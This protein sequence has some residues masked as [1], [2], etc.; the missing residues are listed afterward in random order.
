MNNSK[1]QQLSKGDAIELATRM[2]NKAR[3][4]RLGAMETT[5]KVV[6]GAVSTVAAFAVGYWMGG[7][8]YEKSKLTEAEIEADGDPTK[9]AGMDK[10]LV[11]GV[12]VAGLGIANV[13]GRKVAPVLESAGFGTLAG[14]AYSRGDAQG[15]DAS[16]EAA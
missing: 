5:R 2:R 11:V 9:V 3:N 1:L 14:W 15:F 16:K 10:D 8:R 4:V 13:G 7:L 6:H 12:V